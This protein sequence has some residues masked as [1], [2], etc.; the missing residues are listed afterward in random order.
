[1]VA[2]LAAVAD[3]TAGPREAASVAAAMPP[4]VPVAVAPRRSRVHGRTI[5]GLGR[6]LRAALKSG[7]QPTSGAGKPPAG[8]GEGGLLEEPTQEGGL[9]YS[10]HTE[11]IEACHACNFDVTTSSWEKPKKHL[12]ASS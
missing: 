2:E 10:D 1:M 7:Q 8:T 6:M 3:S 4:A 5:S 11:S 9:M 12:Q